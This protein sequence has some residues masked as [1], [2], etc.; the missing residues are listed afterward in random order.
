MVSTADGFD[1]FKDKTGNIL[2]YKLTSTTVNG[3]DSHI[4]LTNNKQTLISDLSKY[5]DLYL[6]NEVIKT[7]RNMVFQPIG[8]NEYFDSDIN[9]RNYLILSQYMLNEKMY[10]TFKNS[11][12]STIIENINDFGQNATLLNDYFDRYWIQKIKPIFKS[13]T[14]ASNKFLDAFRQNNLTTYFNYKPYITNQRIEYTYD[15]EDNSIVSKMIE[16]L[17]ATNNTE[18]SKDSWNKIIDGAYLAKVKLL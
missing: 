12:L 8:N 13:E 16:N 4:I 15:K 10:L 5:Y 1:G 3:N 11:L 14:D 6:D 7:D 18:N 9:K 17:G 2:T